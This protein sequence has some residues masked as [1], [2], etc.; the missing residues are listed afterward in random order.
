[1]SSD[2]YQVIEMIGREKG[3]DIELVVHAV[4][5]AYAA[6][7]RKNLRGEEI[8][9]SRLNRD[10]GAIDLYA[11]KT[12]VE[13][14]TNPALEISLEEARRS[15]GEVEVGAS[16]E[17]PRPSVGMGRIS[18]QTAKQVILQ[19][20]R[21]AERDNVYNEYIHRIGELV[22]GTVKR[23]ER[24]DIIVD[25]GKTEALL[26]KR[27]QSP[28]ESYGQGDRIKVVIVSVDKS[29]KGPP[30]IVSRAS[31][32]L[33]EKL[34]EMEVPEIYDSTVT[35]RAAVRE[36]GDRAKIAV[37]SKASDVDP[38][39][40]CVGMKG[41]RVQA[42]IREL[43]RERIDIVEWSHDITAFAEKALSPARVNK[44][45]VVDEAGKRLEVIVD[46]SQLSLAIGK[47]GQNV[48]LASKLIGWRIDVKSEEEKRKEVEQAF[49]RLTAASEELRRTP[50]IGKTTAER[51]IEH[52]FPSL[53]HVARAS[54]EELCSI[55]KIGRSTAQRILDVARAYVAAHPPAPAEG[56]AEA[57]PEEA[58]DSEPETGQES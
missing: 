50:G 24:G 19:K 10:S 55:P 45:Q 40:A 15:F 33:V 28:A 17:L 43:R 16:V 37:Y 4:E 25:I 13:E 51:L 18:A 52:G 31:P 22:N 8:L 7:A 14:V 53:E 36:P 34:F 9:H 32:K 20:V 38:V 44:V 21:E 58:S 30:V 3:V 27:E 42:V 23:F 41:I 1:M 47:K 48:R 35:I 12:V 29:S 54:L 6:A 2:L 57:P 39:G 5:E 46:E 49:A 56:A 26:P 11:V